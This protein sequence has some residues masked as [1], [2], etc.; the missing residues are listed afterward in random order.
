MR[1]AIALAVLL[2]ASAPAAAQTYAS[3]PGTM[4]CREVLPEIVQSEIMQVAV[5][6]WV[7]GFVTGVNNAMIAERRFYFD[8]AG[9]TGM[10]YLQDVIA[11][12]QANPDKPVIAAGDAI[13]RSLVQMD[14]PE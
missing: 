6:S 1:T 7:Q 2:A 9:K 12:C 4:V 3:G 13:V 8:V 10:S 11:Y 14:W 5:M